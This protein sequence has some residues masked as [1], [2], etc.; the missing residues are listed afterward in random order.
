MKDHQTRAPLVDAL[1]RHSRRERISFHAPGHKGNPAWNS[2]LVLGRDATELPGLD[3]LHAP[4]GPIAEAQEL[5]AR[6]YGADHSF[7][8]VNGSTAGIQAL[9]LAALGPGDEI[10]LP[11]YAHRSAVAGLVL[12]GAVPAWIPSRWEAK[13]G[14]NY[15]PAPEDLEEALNRHPRARAVLL[16]N[17]SY[18][19]LCPELKTLIGL[20][21]SKGLLVLID[22]AHG[23]HLRLSGELPPDAL[24][25]GADASV[26]SFHKTLGSLTGSSVLHLAGDRVDPLRVQGTL[27]TLQTSSPSYLLMASLD[28]SRRLAAGRGGR[29]AAKLLDGLRAFREEAVSVAGIRCAGPDLERRPG[30]QGFDSFKLLLVPEFG[31]TRVWARSLGRQGVFLE[32]VAPGYLMGMV[33]LGNTQGSL[34]RLAAAL[35]R[36]STEIGGPQKAEKGPIA[37][38]PSDFEVAMAPRRAFQAS[39]TWI[40]LNQSPGRVCAGCLTVSPPGSVLLCPGEIVSR[41]A[42]AYIEEAVAW[43]DTVQGI[44]FNRGIAGL[45]VV[46]E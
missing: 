40:P 31:D 42:A 38:P 32:M 13:L 3:D 24:S 16:I 41:E 21:R 15:G 1:R 23:S 37:A 20:A 39:Q 26:M 22:E 44:E 46:E 14:L 45:P 27:R 7:F 34:K 35:R 36:T 12:S 28:L 17:P 9:F 10:L 19:G 30:L 29:I 2:S 8:L 5:C 11:R 6:F 4:G 25:L 43:G 33:G 18:Q